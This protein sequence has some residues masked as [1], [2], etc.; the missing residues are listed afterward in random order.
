MVTADEYDAFTR[1]RRRVIWRAGE[2]AKIK[3]RY[4]RRERR[5]AVRAIRAELE[6]AAVEA[7]E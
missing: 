3:R 5:A 6:Q 2:V 4:R 7:W 1:W